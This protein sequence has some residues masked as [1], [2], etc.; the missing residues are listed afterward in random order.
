MYHRYHIGLTLVSHQFHNDI[1]RHHIG[2]T[3]ITSVSH[4]FHI[5]APQAFF[6]TGRP[7]AS[8]DTPRATSQDP[9]RATSRK[10]PGAQRIAYYLREPPRPEIAPGRNYAEQGHEIFHWKTS[11]EIRTFFRCHTSASMVFIAEEPLVPRAGA[12]STFG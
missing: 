4:W 6:S 1:T 2:I 11:N 12:P 3:S 9:P 5:G 8:Q 7:G 10:P